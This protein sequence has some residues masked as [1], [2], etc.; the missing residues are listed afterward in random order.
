MKKIL[1]PI[2]LSITVLICNAQNTHVSETKQVV[3]TISKGVSTVYTD[4][5]SLAPDVKK[6]L[7]EV[8]KK[9]G[10]TVE[11]VWL[12]LVYQQRVNSIY[13]LL[14]LLSTII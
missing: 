11:H 12:T 3:D 10:V 8:A 9:A 6:S 4:I 5:K 2:F 13:Y 1:I 14:C 7:N